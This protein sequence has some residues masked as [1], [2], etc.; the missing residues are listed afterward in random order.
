MSQQYETALPPLNFGLLKG[1]RAAYYTLGCKLNFSETSTVGGDLEAYGVERA[2]EGERA[3]ICVINTCSVTS[4]ADKKGRNLIRQVV[5]ANPGAVVV[6]TGCYAQL[7]AQ[8][9]LAIEGVS[10]V[11]G[12]GRKSEIAQH[13]TELLT[14]EQNGIEISRKKE[15][16]TGGEQELQ[17]RFEEGCSRDDRTRHFL[18]VQDGCNYAC[19]YCTIPKAR[20]RSRNGSIA[21]MVAAA[22]R[23]VEAG[24]REIVLTGVNIGDY[25]RTT[26]ERLEDLVKALDAVE[27]IERYRISSLEPELI[28]DELIDLVAA[29][30]HFMPH[31]HIPLQSGSD[32]VLRLMRRRYRRALFTDRIERIVRM[33]PDAFIGLDVIVG[34]R[35]ETDDLFEESRSFLRDTPFTRLHLFTYSERKDTAALSIPHIVT[36]AKKRMRSNLLQELSS[37]HISAFYQRFCGQSRPVLW[38]STEHEGYMHGFTDNYIKLAAPF[39][40]TAIAQVVPAYIGTQLPHNEE[41]CMGTLLKD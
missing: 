10:I 29:S 24:G 21:S 16:F 6:V 18:K 22:E 2:E 19:S 41:Q 4:Q 28:S 38:E 7:A 39:D 25:G 36:P 1:K 8:E 32:E 5:R 17:H 23:V 14:A 40:P 20:G 13:I 12:S 26:G 15:I 27:G 3:D 11:V 37:Q 34:M 33:M 9:I 31:W 35:G 30:K